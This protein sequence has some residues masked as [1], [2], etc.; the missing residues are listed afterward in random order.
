MLVL[1]SMLPLNCDTTEASSSSFSVSCSTGSG[2]QTLGL[3]L[4]ET[5]KLALVAGA[6]T[7]AASAAAAAILTTGEVQQLHQTVEGDAGGLTGGGRGVWEEL[8]T[9]SLSAHNW[10]LQVIAGGS[11][12]AKYSVEK[13]RKEERKRGRGSEEEEEE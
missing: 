1:T 4:R 6:S 12:T 7:A 2:H 9:F 13:K 11:P 8:L 10:C 3:S 5:F